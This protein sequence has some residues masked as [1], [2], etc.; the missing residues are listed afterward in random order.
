MVDT[1]SHAVSV[2]EFY[3]Q[4]SQPN[5]ILLL[6]VRNADEFEEWKVETRHTP[7]TLHIPYFDFLEDEEGM[8]K[9][10]PADR[11]VYA[12]CAKGGGSEYVADVLRS[13]GVNAVN[14]E[15]GMKD[16]GDY[17][18]FRTITETD[19]Y[20]VYQVD[21]VSRGCLSHILVSNGEAVIIDPLRHIGRY[22]D[23]L[24]EKGITLKLLLDTHAHA[25]HISGGPAL[26]KA[27]GAPYYLHPYDGIH[28]FDILP[29]RIDYEMM[30]DGQTFTVGDLTIKVIHTPGH[31]LGQ[32]NFLATAS[33]GEAFFF[34]GDTLFIDSFGRP[35]LGGQGE[36]WA[37]I[38]YETLFKTI[39]DNVP[40]NAH[41]MPGHYA[42]PKEANAEGLYM[43]R[44]AD[45]WTENSA[46]RDQTRESFIEYVLNHLPHM[47]EQ[48]IEIKRVNAGLVEP[49][50]E[51]A[52]ELELGKNVCA[53]SEAYE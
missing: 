1:T 29:P 22:Q 37:P 21:R 33:D 50:E 34:S 39:K 20:Q 10:V 3:E 9:K 27:S 42:Q 18:V 49:D 16:W 30:K 19:S 31:T 12:I 8:S 44:M 43:R 38:V 51:K 15:G 6:D 46:L 32:V 17:Y 35:D 24:G 11:S 13:N 14:I 26:S 7:E 4:I 5:D 52:S 45:L 25:D 41:M 28:P 36:A 2:A 47:P 23:F 48:Y 53:L 40:G